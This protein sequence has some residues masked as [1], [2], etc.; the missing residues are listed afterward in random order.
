MPWLLD[1]PYKGDL[2]MP[3]ILENIKSQ[4]WSTLENRFDGVIQHL[5]E[6]GFKKFHTAGFC[7]GVY[8]LFKYANKVDNFIN[9]VGF[10]PSIGA[11]QLFGENPDDI[12]KNVKCP[13]YFMPAQNDPDNL[14][15]NGDYVK[16]L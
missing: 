8:V 1:P 11:A 2:D 13:A 15:A 14:R 10:H 4:K 9:I 6:K 12:V 16:I 3:A 5:K 7:L